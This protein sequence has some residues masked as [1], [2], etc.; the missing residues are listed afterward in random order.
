MRKIGS[1]KPDSY[2]YV[3]K[4]NKPKS[5]K[6][7]VKVLL[8]EVNV[9]CHLT[10]HIINQRWGGNFL[11]QLLYMGMRSLVRELDSPI[12]SLMSTMNIQPFSKNG[13]TFRVTKVEKLTLKS[14]V[15]VSKNQ[16]YRCFQTTN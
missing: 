6:L 14:K 10:N 2:T 5:L 13:S 11:P 4:P 1:S 16:K 15:K 8:P 9:S 12:D 3:Y 7:T